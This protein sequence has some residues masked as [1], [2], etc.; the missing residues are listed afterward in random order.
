M[1]TLVMTVF[2]N[3]SY[4]QCYRGN[5]SMRRN[6]FC[7]YIFVYECV[8]SFRTVSYIGCGVCFVVYVFW[9]DSIYG[10][11]RNVA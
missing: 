6:R 3:I 7:V 8:A 5:C 1:M 11:E 9:R 10:I 2:A 4:R